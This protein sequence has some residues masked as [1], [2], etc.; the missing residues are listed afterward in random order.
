MKLNI[1]L[2][3][4][5]LVEF[6]KPSKEFKILLALTLVFTTLLVNTSYYVYAFLSDD[7]INSMLDL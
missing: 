5:K 2:A 6:I 7:S 3:K 4:K 1:S